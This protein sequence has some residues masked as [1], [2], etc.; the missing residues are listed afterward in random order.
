MRRKN[1]RKAPTYHARLFTD[2]DEAHE[3]IRRMSLK[4]GNDYHYE[5]IFNDEHKLHW[6]RLWDE[7]DGDGY[8]K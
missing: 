5:V 2:K 8:I 6:A 3:W 4:M 1:I 7:R